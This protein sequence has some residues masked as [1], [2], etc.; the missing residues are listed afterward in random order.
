MYD[1]VICQLDCIIFVVTKSLWGLLNHFLQTFILNSFKFSTKQKKK[2]TKNS[3]SWMTSKLH[4][5]LVQWGLVE[6]V[7]NDG[8]LKVDLVLIVLVE[9]P[10]TNGCETW[11]WNN[12]SVSLNNC[13]LILKFLFYTVWKLQK[14]TLTFW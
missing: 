12:F 2:N 8:Q 10:I 14:F 5:W 9:F 13:E 7:L 11:K 4:M 1:L 6:E 3:L